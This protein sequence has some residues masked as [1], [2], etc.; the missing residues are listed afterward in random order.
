VADCAANAGTD[1]A[2]KRS[3]QELKPEE[4]KGQQFSTQ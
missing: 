4:L 2:E 3:S 1:G